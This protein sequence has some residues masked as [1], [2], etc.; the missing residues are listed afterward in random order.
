M[1]FEGV[2]SRSRYLKMHNC[3]FDKPCV[4]LKVVK[5]LSFLHLQALLS[6]ELYVSN[7][8][9]PSLK[10]IPNMLFLKTKGCTLS[11]IKNDKRCKLS[12]TI[13]I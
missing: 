5:G 13:K 12:S 10:S 9:S 2:K 8:F 6:T 1:V 7:K 4:E 3:G 11:S